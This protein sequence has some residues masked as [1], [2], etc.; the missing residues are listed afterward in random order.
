MPN[1]ACGW[2]AV[3][4]LVFNR[5]WHFR[6]RHQKWELCISKNRKSDD[7]DL[8]VATDEFDVVANGADEYAGGWGGKELALC[9]LDAFAQ[10]KPNVG[11]ERM[12]ARADDT[13]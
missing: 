2:C 1:K 6:A 12:P 3:D 4:G 11:I 5:S 10:L 9:V 7:I 8:D 13:K